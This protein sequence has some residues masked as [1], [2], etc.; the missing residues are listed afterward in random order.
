MPAYPTGMLSFVLEDIDR[1]IAEV[2]SRSQA[3]RTESANTDIPSSRILDLYLFLA[4]SRV[5]LSAAGATPGIGAYAQ[6][7]KNNPTLDV[8]AA[9]NSVISALDAVTAWI[10]AN[11]PKDVATQALLAKIFSSNTIIDRTFPPASTAGFRTVLDALI[12]TI[13]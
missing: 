13:A 2:K 10:Q 6:Q 7:A 8:V 4:Q 9:F 1:T 5:S 3:V 11:F 12:A